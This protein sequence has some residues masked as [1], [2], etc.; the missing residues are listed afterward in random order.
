[1]SFCYYPVDIFLGIEPSRDLVDFPISFVRHNVCGTKIY[2]N[3]STVFYSYSRLARFF[4]PQKVGGVTL[5]SWVL[6]QRIGV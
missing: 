4:G 2:K 3:V 6:H 5:P 1:M